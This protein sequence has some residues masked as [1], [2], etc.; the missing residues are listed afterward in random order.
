LGPL[1]LRTEGIFPKRFYTLG[2][3]YPFLPRNWGEGP[4]FFYLGPPG[5][6]PGAY[7]L[8]GG[9][10]GLPNYFYGGTVFGWGIPSP[11]GRGF[12]TPLS[13]REGWEK[14]VSTFFVPFFSLLGV[15]LFFRGCYTHFLPFNFLGVPPPFFG[16]GD[17][18]PF[19]WGPLGGFFSPFLF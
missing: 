3:H 14:P 12:L 5:F 9:F 4:F 11:L 2:L 16:W 18:P 6:Y 19:F 10:N 7:M 8:K 17:I 1:F 13:P 15:T